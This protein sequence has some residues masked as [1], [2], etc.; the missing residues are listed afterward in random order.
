MISSYSPLASVPSALPTLSL[1]TAQHPITLGGKTL[2]FSFPSLTL[3]TLTNDL[4]FG[5]SHFLVALGLVS[6]VGLA[7]L[8][9]RMHRIRNDTPLRDIPGPWLASCSPLWR[10]WYAVCKS[11]Y[12]HDLTN[13]HRKYGNIVRIAPNE[14]SV[15]D[16][17]F[18]SEIYSHGENVYPKCDMYVFPSHH[19]P[20]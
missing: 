9:K 16:P 18:V 20:S 12:H 5:L 11:N 2:T 15:W 8:A 4:T 6:V 19:F 13:L 17:E 14:V 10:F 7:C 1:G 3:S